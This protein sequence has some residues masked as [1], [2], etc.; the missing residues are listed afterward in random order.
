MTSELF[1]ADPPSSSSMLS[2]CPGMEEWRSELSTSFTELSMSSAVL[3]PPPC[4]LSLDRPSTP[5]SRAGET[6]KKD[7]DEWGYNKPCC[8]YEGI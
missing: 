7:R 8:S 2:S 3:W 4:Q 6:R 5:H 1:G